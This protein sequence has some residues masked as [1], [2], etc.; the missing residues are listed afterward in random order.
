VKSFIV[1]DDSGIILRSGQCPDSMVELQA[2][3][4]GERVMVGVADD[5]MHYID[6]GEVA[7]RMQMGAVLDGTTIRGLPNPSTI[8]IEGVKYIVTDGVAELEFPIPGVYRVRCRAL[9]R[10][11]Q[12]FVVTAP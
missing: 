9:H 4:P 8:K 5:S 3:A 2:S 6:G 12:E 1:Y 11:P 10:I 7:D